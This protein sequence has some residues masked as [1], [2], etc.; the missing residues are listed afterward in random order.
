MMLV[1][2]GTNKRESSGRITMLDPRGGAA[3]IGANAVGKTSTLRLIPLF[4]GHPV[5]QVVSMHQG[6]E[7]VHFI[8]PTPR[9]AI[10]FEYQRG[11]D[12]PSDLRLA[13]MRARSDG[14]DAAEYRIY[15]TGFRAD[16]FVTD[17]QFLTDFGTE[18]K[19]RLFEIE[20]TRKLTTGDYRA[21]ILRTV[22]NSKDS[23]RLLQDAA[24][25]SFGPGPLR[26]LD[27]L[28]A[29]ML[30]KGVKFEE[31][32]QIAVGLIQDDIGAG[33]SN[34]KLS[35][36]QQ[37]SQI[38]KWLRNRDAAEEAIR[39]QPRINTLGGM[40][41]DYGTA[42][43]EWRH[44]R[45]DVRAL[46]AARELEK[47]AKTKEL[48]EFEAQRI[49]GLQAEAQESARIANL[50]ASANSVS[51]AASTAYGAAR[52]QQQHY[53]HERAE[54]WSHELQQLEPMTLRS[55]TLARQVR[56][57]MAIAESVSIE[58]TEAVAKLKVSASESRQL[59]ET[60]K[61]PHS[62][63]YDEAIQTITRDEEIALATLN[64]ELAAMRTSLEEQRDPLLEKRGH[65]QVMVRNPELPPELQ[66]AL[67]DIGNKL[68]ANAN[69][70]FRA[71]GA[72]AEAGRAVS[73]LESEFVESEARQ[74]R[75]RDHLKQS[76]TALAVAKSQLAPETG[77]LLSA[78]RG[79]TDD[80]WKRNLAKVVNP[81]LLLRA[82]L[83]PQALSDELSESFYGWSVATGVIATPEWT[84]D[85]AMRAVVA[86][87]QLV[88]DSAKSELDS[89][90]AKVTAS[91][92]AL[93]ASRDRHTRL[94]SEES[95][96]ASK[97]T[98]L[99]ES[100][101]L[102]TRAIEKARSEA[103][104]DA[105]AELAN[106]QAHIV[107]VVAQLKALDQTAT[108]RRAE[109]ARAHTV[110]R[111]EAL[112]R[113]KDAIDGINRAITRLMS[114]S[115][116]LLVDMQE[117]FNRVLADKGVDVVRV[118]AMKLE[119]TGVDDAIAALTKRVP[120]VAAWKTWMSE[121]G[122]ERVSAMKRDAESAS[123]NARLHAAAREAH[124]VVIQTA[125]KT[126]SGAVST[127]KGA[128]DDIETDLGI[129]AKLVDEFGDY[130]P[131]AHEGFDTATSAKALRGLIQREA[132]ALADS[133]KNIGTAFRDL[134]RHLTSRDSTVKELVEAHLTA[135]PGDEVAQARVLCAAYRLLG[136]QVIAD[137]NTTLA[138]V[139]ANIG[140]FRKAL[141]AFESEVGNFN[142][143]LQRGLNEIT[144]F[145]R[146]EGLKLDIVAD[147]E[148][149]GFYRKLTRMDEVVRRHQSDHGSNV[150]ADMPPASTA[151]AL[152]DFMGVIGTDGTLEVNLAAHVHLH[153]SVVENGQHRQFRKASE[154]E[155]VSSTGL[156]AIILITLLVGLVNTVRRSDAVHVPWVTDEVGAF[157]PKNFKSL[158]RLLQDNHIDVITASPALGMSQLSLFA[159]RYIFAD[160]GEI[161]LYSE[162]ARRAPSLDQVAPVAAVEG[163]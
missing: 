107:E 65:W 40:C 126:H 161:R 129:L 33:G 3:V 82:D 151:E 17:R 118:A 123:T 131:L 149:L 113:R 8:L 104:G 112:R 7:G 74:R 160:R 115:E 55:E 57:A 99:E 84:D 94:Q 63:E 150:V 28:V 26:D 32:V 138:T 76:D 1:N 122:P 95:I 143:K 42:E 139:L 38:E 61:A 144:R 155:H 136:S 80:A 81:E 145:D 71:Q 141:A 50:V 49:F 142:R 103:K 111:E 89:Q 100:K 47:A 133:K 64:A 30:K 11:S 51:T 39:M 125:A 41:L 54:H 119:L 59:L 121:V 101:N 88:V 156:S 85:E 67:A 24:M 53:E 45:S 25:H 9:S 14:S 31:L 132:I 62:A 15:K 106:V 18:E 109:V 102:A 163:A 135:S 52:N 4:F 92:A 93:T 19:A 36:K 78:L 2:A 43:T 23:R 20:G 66:M 73:K 37:R 152:R 140:Q 96:L 153:G 147:F 46:T 5:S 128:I 108:G 154:L 114:E 21:I 60:S 86:A 10:C 70:R 87:A 157:D 77:T 35:M 130:A 13:V 12:D 68:L 159:H 44:R 83:D 110:L 98:S 22:A 127:L 120:I 79:H 91:S 124:E 6:Q 58:H 162:P 34:Q 29:T 148:G 69:E 134:L 105:D 90:T 137:I 72:T 16:M 56:G 48:A 158:L 27:K 75:I 116:A 117:A 97:R 146:V